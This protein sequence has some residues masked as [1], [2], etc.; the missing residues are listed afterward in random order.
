MFFF[1]GGGECL[2]STLWKQGGSSNGDAVVFDSIEIFVSFSSIWYVHV[3]VGHRTTMWQG[4]CQVKC[5]RQKS[6]DATVE[7]C[8]AV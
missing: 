8:A 3:V 1:V 2:F 7:G 4:S 5:D 6:R